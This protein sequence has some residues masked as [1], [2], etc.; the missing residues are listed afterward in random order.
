MA[1]REKPRAVLVDD[2]VFEWASKRRWSVS[3]G[4]GYAHGYSCKSGT[5]E[6]LHR[7]IMGLP[8]GDGLQ[9]DHINGDPLDNRRSNLRIATHL[10]NHQNMKKYGH[11]RFQIGRS[12]FKGVNWEPKGWKASITSKGQLINLGHFKTEEEAA[13]AYDEAAIKYFGEFGKLNF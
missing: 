8:K 1:G 6:T 7:V 3:A 9:V 11:G 2:D 12:R 5:I 4:G 13:R 10:Q